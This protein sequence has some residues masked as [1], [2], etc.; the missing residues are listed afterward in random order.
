MTFTK[1]FLQN[2]IVVTLVTL[3]LTVVMTRLVNFNST[4]YICKTEQKKKQL[5]LL[6]KQI[7]KMENNRNK[8]DAMI[9][10]NYREN[11]RSSL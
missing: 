3:P 8:I 10:Q 4:H 7:S 5:D 9:T 11:I 2:K 1:Q 6:I